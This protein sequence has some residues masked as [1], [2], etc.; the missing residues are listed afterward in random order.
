MCAVILAASAATAYAEAPAPVRPVNQNL[1]VPMITPEPVLTD[2]AAGARGD[3]VLRLQKRLAVLGFFFTAEDGIYGANTQNAV[4]EFENYLRLLEQDQINLLIEANKTPEPTETPA[5]SETPTPEPAGTPESSDG[6]A[7]SETPGAAATPSPEPT[8]EPTPVPTPKTPAD[9]MADVAIQ[10]MM[11]GD[12]GALY[13]RDVQSGDSG[14]DITR[15]QRRLVYLNYLNDAPDG[16]FGVNTENAVKAFQLAHDM[17][18]TGTADQATQEK[19]Y[20]EQ[21]V[22]AERPVYNQLYLGVTGEDVKT[23]QNQLRIL[24]FMNAKA[25]GVY[26]E[27]TR[28]AVVLLESYLHQLD[29][30]EGGEKINEPQSTPVP[31]EILENQGEITGDPEVN[32]YEV[33]PGEEEG[34]AHNK[35]DKLIQE[36]VADAVEPEASPGPSAMPMN[37]NTAENAQ[38]DAFIPTGVMTAE[39][40]ERLLEEGIPVCMYALR[41]GDAGDQ[42]RRVQRRLYSL[43]YLTA[44]GVDGIFGKGSEAAV[45]AFQKRN[46]L[47]ETGVADE[48]TQAL[49][50]SE[51]AVKSIKPYQIQIS[52][53]K[54]RVYVYTHDEND[55]YTVKVK[56]FIC[57]TGL[58]STP[59]PL[60]TFTNTGPGARWHYFKKFECWA[61]YAYYINGDIMFH[62]VI[63]NE[64]DESTLVKSSLNNLGKRASHG[65]VRLKVE[66]AA[67]IYNNCKAGTTVI[68]Y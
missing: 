21:A 10:E 52:V 41:K 64:Q 26:D 65:C 22:R 51:D 4:L 38:E 67:W 62:S 3:D 63:Y 33:L 19:L 30:A 56:E 45:L 20:S 39:M 34:A 25:S 37:P 16:R 29:M 12:V 2:L 46:K 68:V 49:L 23:V 28:D 54:Q 48:E 1:K 14:A 18:A 27:K 17:N 47:P 43:A 40:Q 15:I 66:D 13:R 24:G 61:Q 5:P 32:P 50:F 6:A 55:E 42:V 9:G 35:P 57:S 53:D 31:E 7:A 58:K 36:A 44:N 59:T 8:L 60:G 11:F